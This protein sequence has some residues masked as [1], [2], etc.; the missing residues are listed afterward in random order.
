MSTPRSAHAHHHTLA[1]EA[2]LTGDVAS[3]SEGASDREKRTT[4][5]YNEREGLPFSCALLGAF[6]T[7]GVA[8][9]IV[10]AMPRLL[11]GYMHAAWEDARFH[12]RMGLF[13]LMEESIFWE[14]ED[15]RRIMA[16]ITGG[17]DLDAR[18]R[19]LI[20]QA[21]TVL[22]RSWLGVT[23]TSRSETSRIMYRLVGQ[24]SHQWT[25]ERGELYSYALH[26]HVWQHIF[27]EDRARWLPLLDPRLFTLPTSR[28]DLFNLAWA[29]IQLVQHE[30]VLDMTPTHTTSFVLER[31]RIIRAISS[32]W[33]G[34]GNIADE[35]SG[36][37][38]DLVEAGMLAG[39]R[40]SPRKEGAP[41]AGTRIEITWTDTQRERLA[42]HVTPSAHFMARSDR[43]EA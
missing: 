14:Y 4:F 17:A 15:G 1:I 43:G 22:A 26:E 10:S 7:L 41:E 28:E 35:I 30:R 11:E 37:L 25:S 3:S 32:I 42:G 5:T 40:A 38:D 18:A 23:T 9:R 36:R 29:L 34:E 21:Q 39:W 2:A 16:L 27:G 8:P 31:A 13:Y 20:A 19:D 6:V 24:R 33:P 12:E